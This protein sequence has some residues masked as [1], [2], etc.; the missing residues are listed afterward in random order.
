[1]SVSILRSDGGFTDDEMRDQCRQ[2]A[3]E[4]DGVKTFDGENCD[5]GVTMETLSR[6]TLYRTSDDQKCWNQ[7][8][9]DEWIKPNEMNPNTRANV[10][11]PSDGVSFDVQEILD[12]YEQGLGVH[13]VELF[14]RTVQYAAAFDFVSVQRLAEKGLR[15]LAVILFDRTVRY[16]TDFNV[17]RL[18]VLKDI[19]MRERAVVLFDRTAR[20]V[21][22]FDALSIQLLLEYGLGDLAAKL[23][24][25]TKGYVTDF[26]ALS[27]RQQGVYRHYV[28]RAFFQRLDFL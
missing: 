7:R 16:V 14:N 17:R 11:L 4:R 5:D 10:R 22:S 19:G 13:A 8:T 26:S 20:Y 2:C 24:D 12:L 27:A 28:G 23:F 21:T 25:K 6:H 18:R 1:M 3:E 9:Y 15:P